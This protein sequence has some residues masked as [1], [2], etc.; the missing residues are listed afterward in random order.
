MHSHLAILHIDAIP[1]DF[2]AE[3]RE[4][5]QADGL[6]IEVQSRP[7]NAAFAAVEWLMPTAVVAYLARPYFES[8]LKE[9]G[10]DH[11]E[12]LK[13]GLK[14]LYIRTAGPK[15]PEV[16]LVSTVGKVSPEQPYSLFFSIVAQGPEKTQFKL[17]IQRPIT[18]SDYEAA[19]SSFLDFIQQVHTDT[20]DTETIAAYEGTLLTGKTILV[21][22]SLETRTIVPVNPFEGR[23]SQ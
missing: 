6:K 12:L 4:I 18:Q 11:Y 9:M 17:L 20:L 7:T 23:G 22:Y 16:S 19:V 1:P 10:K 8:F 21:A 14:R 2:F 15:A 5:I 13:E 3:F